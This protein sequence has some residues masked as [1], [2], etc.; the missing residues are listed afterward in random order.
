MCSGL[1]LLLTIFGLWVACLS[2]TPPARAGTVRQAND[3]ILDRTTQTIL[4]TLPGSSTDLPTFLDGPCD[5]YLLVTAGAGYTDVRVLAQP[6]ADPKALAHA[7]ETSVAGTPLEGDTVEWSADRDAAAHLRHKATHRGRSFGENPVPINAL[8]TGLRRAGFDPH[9]LL[10]V[11][12]YAQVIGLPAA[13]TSTAHYHWYDGHALAHVGTS[14][15]AVR[16][17]A[18]LRLSDLWPFAL[19]LLIPCLGLVCLGIARRT[20]RAENISVEVRRKRFHVLSMAPCSACFS[21][22][23]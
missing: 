20:G 6:S 2:L 12:R 1:R 23:R 16:V 10:R 17:R 11:P 5:V 15:S 13:A 18:R 19:P 7:L 3:P 8:I 9:P 4:N 14:A 21:G 22:C